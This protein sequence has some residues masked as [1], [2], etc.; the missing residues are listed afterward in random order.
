MKSK[1]EYQMPNGRD[2]IF[3][4]SSG[5]LAAIAAAAPFRNY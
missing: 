5:V 3:L 2:F 4:E 1:R